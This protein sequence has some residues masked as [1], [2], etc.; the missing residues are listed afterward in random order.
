MPGYASIESKK[1]EL[2]R[3]GI[4]G[5]VF[6]APYTAAPIVISTLFGTTG[7]LA[8]LPSGYF[9]MGWTDDTGAVFDRKITTTDVS[10]WGTVDPLRMDITADTTTLVVNAYETN[11]VN[12]GLFTNVAQSALVAGANGVLAVPVPVATTPTLYRV[13]ALGIDESPYGEIVIAR[14]LPNAQ[15]TDFKSQSYSMK[16]PISYGMTFTANLDSPSGYAQEM[17]YGGAGWQYMLTDAGVSR[18]IVC[19]VALS[20]ALVATTGTFSQ[21]DVGATVAGVGLVGGQTIASVTNATNAVLSAAGTVAGS[22]VSVT[23]S[24]PL[25]LII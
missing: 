21:D 16:D 18:V 23:V 2:I 17:I 14:Y 24:N 11:L 6:V 8:T 1:A 19:T 20:T 15:V 5:S 9:D 4:Q 25:Q 10:G 7:D 12:I 22:A 13:L 3:K